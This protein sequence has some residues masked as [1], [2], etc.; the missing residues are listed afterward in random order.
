LRRILSIL[1]FILLIAIQ[2]QG[3]VARETPA[4]TPTD[5]IINLYPNPATTYITF[6]LQKDYQKGLSLQVFSFLG[7][8]MYETKNLPQKLMLD[9]TEFNRGL[10]MYQLTDGSGRVV[11]SGKFQ[12]TK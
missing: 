2:S 4:S 1:S 9:L 11:E 10:Y 5:R 7:K 12:V 3:Q 6:D 8:K